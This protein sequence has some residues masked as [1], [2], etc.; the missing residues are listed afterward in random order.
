MSEQEKD[1]QST[2]EQ[3]S[4][5]FFIDDELTEAEL[6][7]EQQRKERKKR[8]MR[9]VLMK[10]CLLAACVLLII[11]VCGIFV[12]NKRK[13]PITIQVKNTSMIQGEEMPKYGIE[14]KSKRNP[15]SVLDKKSGYTY[16]DLRKD[17]LAGKGLNIECKAD[18]T[19][20]G[21]FPIKASL[22]KELKNKVSTKWK[23]KVKFIFEDGT[24]E[25]KNQYGE[26]EK[27]KF[28]YWD[29]KY[30]SEKFIPY[31]GK[32]YYFD[33][34]GIMVTG[35]MFIGTR[36]YTF[37]DKG[38]LVSEKI[39]IDPKKPMVA[40]TFDDG[41][42][43]RTE[44]LLNVLDE[45][46]S[47][48]TFFML[49]KNV[50]RYEEVVKKMQDLGNELGNHSWDHENLAQLSDEDIKWEINHTNEVIK[51]AA[52]NNPS[53]MRPPY[54]SINATVR[55]NVG[56]P[57][58]MW[59]IDTEDWKTRDAQKTIEVVMNNVKDGDIIL[60]HDIHDPS[61]DAAIQLIPQLVDKGY[62]LVTVSEMAQIKGVKTVSG[63]KYFSFR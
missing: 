12:H 59:S 53:L 4:Q 8:R 58:I 57:L 36:K 14:V 30:A 11:V 18:G 1:L 51:N 44:E 33:K 60:I 55:E 47:R 17:L 61:V 24:L 21:K 54:G 40:L 26:M 48:A 25:V 9:A 13:G 31:H 56:L 45:N 28:K 22:S 7:R 42:G 34:D 19:K 37:D 23:K 39:E 41:P 6:E 20:E 43:K 10:R 63:E 15:K 32:T 35:D 62:Q 29:G 50:S 3:E 49:G 16:K 52:G 46:G 38:A 27:N 2:E 5:D